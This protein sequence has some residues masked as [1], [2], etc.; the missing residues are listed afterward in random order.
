MKL[1]LQGLT[2]KNHELKILN[3]KGKPPDRID[4]VVDKLDSI[5]SY[6]E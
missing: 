4:L 3:F 6:L 1:Y 5:F 2:I